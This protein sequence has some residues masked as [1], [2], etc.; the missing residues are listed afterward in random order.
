MQSN[1]KDILLID[2]CV[3]LDLAKDTSNKTII[4]TIKSLIDSESIK[5]L[6]PNIIKEEFLRNKSKII[7]NS[8]KKISREIKNVKEIVTQYDLS[9][10]KSTILNSLTD[11]NH[12]LPMLS[13]L[14]SE[15]VELIWEIIESID[16]LEINDSDKIKS[17]DRALL[18]KAPF[19]NKKESMA[20]SLIIELFFRNAKIDNQYNYHFVTHN[21]ND[22][23][24]STD[25]RVYHSDFENYFSINNINYST[26]LLSLIKSISPDTLDD[27]TFEYEWDEESRGFNEILDHI[28]ILTDKIWYDRHSMRA[29]LIEEGKIKVVNKDDYDVMNPNQIVKNIWDGALKLAKNKEEIYPNEL[30]PWSSF[31]WGM[32]NGKLSALRW[33]L[34]EDWDML[35]T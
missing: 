16:E 18:K 6:L 4:M 12:K 1:C 25:K 32:M 8:K 24:S 5:I 26:D 19:H 28:N 33:V 7:D 34:G 17:S 3:W 27:I 9:D 31:E 2:T 35:D 30:G 13:D 23:S 21:T 14:I 22:F 10:N 15:Q 11:I 29:N 20:D